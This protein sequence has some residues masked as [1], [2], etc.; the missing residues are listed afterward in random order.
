MVVLISRRSNSRFVTL[1]KLRDLARL[2][3]AT[4]AAIVLLGCDASYAVQRTIEWADQ[5]SCRKIE[6][7]NHCWF[8]SN[9]A[10]YEIFA[11]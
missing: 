5:L 6:P 3:A 2:A 4:L 1:V 8:V 9:P 10:A 11:D 7:I